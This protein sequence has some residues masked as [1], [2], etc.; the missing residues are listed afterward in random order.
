MKTTAKDILARGRLEIEIVS[1]VIDALQRMNCFAWRQNNVPSRIERDGKS[2]M[3]R[4]VAPAGM[5]D[6]GAIAPGGR[7]IQCEVKRP[8]GRPTDDQC[9]WLER[10]MENGAI[11]LIARSTDDVAAVYALARVDGWDKV[12]APW[13]SDPERIKWSARTGRRLWIPPPSR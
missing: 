12:E 10:C 9:D 11:S 8:D 6:V 7:A 13:I 2:F 5:A 1:S 3:R 4:G